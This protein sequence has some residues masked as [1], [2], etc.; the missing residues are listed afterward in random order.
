MKQMKKVPSPKSHVAN[1]PKVKTERIVD[2]PI[3]KRY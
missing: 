2:K 1:I 3:G